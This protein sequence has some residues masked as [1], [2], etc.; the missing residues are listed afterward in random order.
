[1]EKENEGVLALIEGYK[2]KLR[3]N[4]LGSEAYKWE[5]LGKYPGRPDLEAPDFGKEALEIDFGLFL[6]L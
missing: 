3:A 1:M 6:V 2:A 4:G 5:L